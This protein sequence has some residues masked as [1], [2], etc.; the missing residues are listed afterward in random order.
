LAGVFFEIFSSFF[1]L[2]FSFFSSP[3]FFRSS[4]STTAFVGSLVGTSAKVDA[5]L[6]AQMATVLEAG[7]HLAAILKGVNADVGLK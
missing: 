4:T 1:L 6:L 2:I 7:W 3:N 5:T